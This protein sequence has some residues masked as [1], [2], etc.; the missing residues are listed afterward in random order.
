MTG[1]PQRLR[2][3]F[4]TDETAPVVLL[5]LLE[6]L[7]D[8]PFTTYNKAES[9]FHP[10][11]HRLDATVAAPVAT[12]RGFEGRLGIRL[13]IVGADHYIDI[14]NAW[15]SYGAVQFRFYDNSFE[16]TAT[17]GETTHVA[18][19]LVLFAYLWKAPIRRQSSPIADPPA[20]SAL[21][22]PAPSPPSLPL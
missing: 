13:N 9:T 6:L 10:R 5:Q 15:H 16:I 20:E 7:G 22:E 4:I 12:E 8:R 11:I 2:E 18:V 17:Y 19:V 1:T 14:L 21:C 3:G